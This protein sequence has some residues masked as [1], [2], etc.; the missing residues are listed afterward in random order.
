MRIRY[1]DLVGRQVVDA[2]GVKVGRI[3][4]LLAERQGERLRVTALL[5]GDAALFQRILFQRRRGARLLRPRVIPWSLV[6]EVPGAPGISGTY[7]R[8]RTTK[9]DLKPWPEVVEEE[10]GDV[11]SDTGAQGGAA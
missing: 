8:L 3:H 10:R 1:S 7:V 9:A 11:S 4:D 6:A 2:D 5:L